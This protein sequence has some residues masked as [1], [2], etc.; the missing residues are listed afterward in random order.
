VVAAPGFDDDELLALAAALETSSE[1]PLSAAIL[2]A[3]R[4]RLVVDEWRINAAR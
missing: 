3:A 2:Q 1:H 4:A